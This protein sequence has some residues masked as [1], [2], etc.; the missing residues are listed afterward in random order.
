M[1]DCVRACD[2]VR[3][4]VWLG[5]CVCVCVRARARVRERCMYNYHI[6]ASIKTLAP[7]KGGERPSAFVLLHFIII[8]LC[9]FVLLFLCMAAQVNYSHSK[10][11][12]ICVRACAWLWA[13]ACESMCI[14]V[15]IPSDY[16][17]WHRDKQWTGRGRIQHTQRHLPWVLSV[18]SNRKI[19]TSVK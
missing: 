3:A 8:I 5:V 17:H 19:K 12:R 4:C 9:C 13:C 15:Y 18:I 7:M 10:H 2:W 14:I 6:A 16:S 1:T 11:T